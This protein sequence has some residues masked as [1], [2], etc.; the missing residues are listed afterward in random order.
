VYLDQSVLRSAGRRSVTIQRSAP[1]VGQR[2]GFLCHSH[3]EKDLALGLQQRLKEEGLDLYIDWQDPGMPPEPDRVTANRIKLV[4]QRA[5]VFLFLA[6]QASMASS[7]CPWEIGFADGAKNINQII[8]VPTRDS[9]GNYH[10]N[11]YLQLYRRLEASSTT[12]PIY[13]YGVGSTVG[14]AVRG[15]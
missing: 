13:W 12:G 7:W 3:H 10:G 2:T 11:E 6:T 14:S 15:L 8:L 5:D 4:I 1:M 9:N